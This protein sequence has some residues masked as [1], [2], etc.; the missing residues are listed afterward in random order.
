MKNL[1]VS[2][3]AQFDDYVA[4]KLCK[5]GQLSEG[6]GEGEKAFWR[7]EKTGIAFERV[8]SSL[9]PLANIRAGSLAISGVELVNCLTKRDYLNLLEAVDNY[10]KKFPKTFEEFRTP[11]KKLFMMKDS[12]GDYLIRSES[13]SEEESCFFCALSVYCDKRHGALGNECD[14]KIDNECW[15]KLEDAVVE[16]IIQQSRV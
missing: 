12:N 10:N 11:D 3:L 9:E 13:N 16:T 8:P 1:E 14:L 4:F 15:V 7:D 6:L 2:V 5:N